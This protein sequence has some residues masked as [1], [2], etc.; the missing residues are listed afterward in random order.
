MPVPMADA[1]HYM[2]ERPALLVQVHT[3]AGIVGLG[4]AAAYGGFLESTEALVTGELRRTILGQDPF[5]V[6]RLWQMMATR[7]Q[8][9]GRRG[10]L[11]MAISGIDI[12]LWDMIGQATKTPLYRLLG[13]Y[14]DRLPV[15]ASAGFYAGDKDAAALGA[16]VAG[17]AER[18]FG[19]VKIKVGR[20]P[21]ALLNPLRDM[22]AADYATVSFDQ[23]VARVRAARAAIGSGVK[24]AIDANNAWTPS[25]AL[26]F[27]RAVEDQDIYWLEEPVA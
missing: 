14:H 26:T 18:G 7:A 8:Q 4:E 16:E 13:G 25:L 9:R 11:M 15:Y 20:Q 19:C 12:A 22:P 5:R 21:D 17:Y 3:D 23:D 10:M 2:P 24:L 1:I 27:M 6:E